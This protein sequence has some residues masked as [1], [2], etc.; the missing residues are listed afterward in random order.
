MTTTPV[1]MDPRIKERR[2]E[3]Q[4]AQGR[5]RLRRLVVALVLVGL[6]AIAYLALRS[7]FLDVDRVQVTGADH[8]SADAIRDASGV[9][10]G[11]ALAF[12]GTGTVEGRIERLP[13]VAD[14]SVTRV[15]PGTLRV[16]VREHIPTA[17]VRDDNGF[18]LLAGNGRALGRVRDLSAGL[19]E[20]RGV[21]RVPADGETVSPADAPGVVARLPEALRTRVQAVEVA[22]GG[23]QLQLREGGV[24]RLG[25]PDDL[26]AK[27]AAAEAV[28]AEPD[29]SP[30]SYLDVSVPQTP[31][32]RR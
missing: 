15:F 26:E 22:A 25:S 12:V 29:A 4:R 9:R 8:V 32:L 2:V 17:Y 23:L 20:V 31:V 5:R 16:T 10:R 27:A 14:A 3:V 24:V 11:A 28:L 7:P 13:W 21:R 19:V 6:G 18:V 1:R 30:F